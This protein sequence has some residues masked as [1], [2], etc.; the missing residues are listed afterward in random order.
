MGRI[1][2]QG[3]PPIDVELRRNSRA[4]RLSL[5]VSRLDGRVTLTMPD[6]VADAEGHRFAQSKAG[7]IAEARQGQPVPMPV[8]M[9][10]ALP[11]EGKIV[12]IVPGAR[13]GP[14]L[15]GDRLEAPVGRTAPAVK[16]Y[17]ID[18]ARARAIPAIDRYATRIGRPA[19]RLSLRDTR[20]RWGS[21]SADGN[22]MLSWRLI[23]APPAVFEYVVAHEVA[24]LVEMN[25]GPRFWAEVKALC[26]DF[27]EMRRWL[28]AEGPA[29]HRYRFD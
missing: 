6:N 15:T 7:W 21:C 1:T 22:L 27:E 5:R 24:H 26:P 3:N 12:R 23:L 11:V 8:E 2:L 29:L 16:A 14:V 9:G 19:G 4:R 13:P 18:R 10:V 25:H 28:R 20:S 17:L